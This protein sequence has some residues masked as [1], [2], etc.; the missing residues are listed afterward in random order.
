L[1]QAG[2][3]ALL[4]NSLSAEVNVNFCIQMKLFCSKAVYTLPIDSIGFLDYTSGMAKVATMPI[5]LDK[6]EETIRKLAEDSANVYFRPHASERLVERGIT[7]TQVLFSLRHGGIVEGPIYE[8]HKQ[9]G[10]KVTMESFYAGRNIGVAAK[11]V[12]EGDGHILVISVF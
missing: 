6:V 7:Q 3:E 8:S 12:E 11:L 10:W 2:S 5:P 1:A 9:K 4:D